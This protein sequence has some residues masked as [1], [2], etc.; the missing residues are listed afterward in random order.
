MPIQCHK[1]EAAI[2]PLQ[3]RRRLTRSYGINCTLLHCS[4]RPARCCKT[5][6]RRRASA[7][8]PSKQR[9]YPI[10]SI[11][12]HSNGE[13]QLGHDRNPPRRQQIGASQAGKNSLTATKANFKDNNRPHKSRASR[14][15]RLHLAAKDPYPTTI[16]RPLNGR[17]IKNQPKRHCRESPPLP[18]HD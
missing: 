17:R 11:S 9:L 3:C 10:T 5:S 6:A 8:E 1:Y 12:L 7:G 16:Q 4:C 13:L 18:F 2:E 15:D 14:Q